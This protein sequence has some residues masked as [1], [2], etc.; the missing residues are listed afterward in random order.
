ML[1]IAL[2][3]GWRMRPW[4]AIGGID[5]ASLPGVVAAGAGRIVVVRAAGGPDPGASVMSLIEGLACHSDD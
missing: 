1:R 2:E 5:D 3:V 4:F